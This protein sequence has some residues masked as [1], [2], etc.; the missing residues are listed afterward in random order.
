MFAAY[1]AFVVAGMGVY[2]LA[3]D[4]PMA[5]LMKTGADLPLLLSWLT[6]QAGALIALLA[7]VI[8]GLPLAWIVI[9]R[10]LT[11]SRQDLRLLLVPVLSF[12]ALVPYAVFVAVDRP[13]A[14]QGSRRH[15]YSDP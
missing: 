8:G 15:A 5:A 7:V 14:L 4:S 1:I 2:G 10:A 3:D 11:S 13:W 12:L 9:R 6:V